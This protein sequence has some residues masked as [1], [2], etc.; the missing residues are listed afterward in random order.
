VQIDDK[1]NPRAQKTHG[2]Q[3]GNSVALS[4]CI[5]IETDLK[6]VTAEQLSEGNVKRPDEPQVHGDPNQGAH[7]LNM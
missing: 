2:R 5:N 4:S 6:L 1:E 7:R 3:P